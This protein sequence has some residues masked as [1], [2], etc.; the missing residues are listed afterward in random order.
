MGKIFCHKCTDDGLISSKYR[1]GKMMGYTR[2]FTCG[3]CKKAEWK[4]KSKKWPNGEPLKVWGPNTHYDLILNY[5]PIFRLDEYF[6]LHPDMPEKPKSENGDGC[7][8][9]KP[10]VDVNDYAKFLKHNAE[11]Q[12]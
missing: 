3:F 7:G 8:F 11:A 2:T 4:A 5:V 6:D 12:P 1:D 10:D 9:K